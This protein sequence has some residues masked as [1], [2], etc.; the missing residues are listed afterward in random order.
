MLLAY[1]G[2][3]TMMP[4]TS[5]LAVVAG[6]F[7]MLGRQALMFCRIGLRK[8]GRLVGLVKTAD[9]K[10]E[11]TAQRNPRV[12]PAEPGVPSVHSGVGAHSE[13]EEADRDPVI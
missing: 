6:V 10:P 7:L 4:M 9:P 8:L 12:D 13:V 2:P 3:E 5:V 1:F 11:T